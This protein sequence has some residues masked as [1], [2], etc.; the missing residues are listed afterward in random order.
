MWKCQ[1]PSWKCVFIRSAV[2]ALV[3]QEHGCFCGLH[4]DTHQE[5]GVREAH[6]WESV[7]LVV[8]IL[9]SS[10]W[11]LVSYMVLLCAA[12]A[13]FHH[14]PAV[15]A[16]VLSLLTTLTLATGPLHLL[17]FLSALF[18]LS[19]DFFFSFPVFTLLFRVIFS[20]RLPCVRP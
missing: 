9:S 5:R 3:S 4:G 17:F 14:I 11:P 10:L 13:V 20:K 6:F 8:I 16:P 1:S 7:Q 12:L 19:Q 2:L 15:P 18:F